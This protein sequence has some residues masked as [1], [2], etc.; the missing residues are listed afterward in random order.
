MIAQAHY[1]TRRYF[2]FDQPVGIRA[3]AE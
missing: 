2:A 3:P 1:M